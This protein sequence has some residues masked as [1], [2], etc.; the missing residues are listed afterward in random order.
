MRARPAGIAGLAIIVVLV[1]AT[2]A[3]AQSGGAGAA[4][5]ARADS[6]VWD[7]LES[8]NRATYNLNSMLWSAVVQPVTGAYR[9]NIPPAVQTGLDNAF[10]NL[11]EPLVAVSSGLQGDF[12]NAGL[13]LGRFAINTTEGILGIYDV[14]TPQG[15]VSRSEDFGSTLCTYGIGTGPYIV[16]PFLGPSTAREATAT[17]ATYAL[18]Y[19][20]RVL[21]GR[22]ATAYFLADRSVAVVNRP[23]LPPIADPYILQR[24]AFL[25]LRRD[26]CSHA[27]APGQLKAGAFGSVTRAPGAPWTR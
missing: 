10:T 5:A 26:V 6:A 1:T 12:H 14:A 22:A 16:L 13:S 3:S 9:S 27:L 17:I 2:C 4:P 21:G 23:V 15:W 8:I 18:G 11:R 24:D 25:A 20:L 19:G 7:P